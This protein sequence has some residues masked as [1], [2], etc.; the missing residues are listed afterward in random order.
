MCGRGEKDKSNIPENVTVVKIKCDCGKYLEEKEV[1]INHILTRMMACPACGFKTLTK[2][3]ATEF[4]KRVKFHQA[5]DQERKII[6]KNL[7]LR[8]PNRP[9]VY[10]ACVQYCVRSSQV[11]VVQ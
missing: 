10:G 11:L 3:Q 5:I 6:P 4:R 9:P 2:E 8:D 7:H 1:M